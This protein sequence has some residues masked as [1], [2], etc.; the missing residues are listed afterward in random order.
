MS[1][2]DINLGDAK[3]PK[4]ANEGE[5]LIR[6]VGTGGGVDKNGHPYI[7]SIFDIPSVP[8]AKSFTHFESLPYEGMEPK[9]LN[10][11]KWRLKLLFE[12]FGIDHTKQIDFVICKGRQAWAILGV[13]EDDQYG[14]QNFVKKFV[15]P[16]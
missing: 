4:A 12:A 6:W 8:D 9:Q 3:E 15:R 11:C 5:Y 16:A 2:L 1:F 7:Q 13:N 10:N 14:K